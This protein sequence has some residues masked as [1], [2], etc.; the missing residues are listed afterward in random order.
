MPTATVRTFELVREDRPCQAAG[1]DRQ[2]SWLHNSSQAKTRKVRAVCDKH[3]FE[4]EHRKLTV[5]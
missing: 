3:R 5:N 1:C 4:I 2:A